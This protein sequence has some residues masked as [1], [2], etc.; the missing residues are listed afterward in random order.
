M[1][2]EDLRILKKNHYY[3]VLDSQQVIDVDNEDAIDPSS[4]FIYIK[5]L[6]ISVAKYSDCENLNPGDEIP[7]V[8]IDSNEKYLDNDEYWLGYDLEVWGDFESSNFEGA[9]GEDGEYEEIT[10]LSF[11]ERLAPYPSLNEELLEEKLDKNLDELLST[12]VQKSNWDVKL[13]VQRLIKELKL[14]NESELADKL[15]ISKNGLSML[16]KRNSLGTLIEKVLEHIDTE[17]SIDNIIYGYGSLPFK[18]Q[19]IARVL[20]SNEKLN[21][22]LNEFIERQNASS[23]FLSSRI[24]QQRGQNFIIKI[25]ENFT[26]KKSFIIDF[27]DTFLRRTMNSK[28]I[29]HK[30]GSLKD[31]LA[32]ELKEYSIVQYGNKVTA[33]EKNRIIELIESELDDSSAFELLSKNITLF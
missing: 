1:K 31:L 10:D 16:K 11:K 5:V 30:Q 23:C 12:R 15:N 24:E 33:E 7:S 19:K 18:A 3:K 22:I 17:I 25:I 4:E 21:N 32:L 26:E 20:D 6:D 2:S 27:L 9:L 14:K 28:A 13:V 8:E 29:F